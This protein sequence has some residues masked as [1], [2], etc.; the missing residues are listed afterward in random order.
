MIRTLGGGFLVIGGSESFAIEGDKTEASLGF[1]N[2][3]MVK[4]DEAGNTQWDR[5]VLDTGLGDGRRVVQLA[6]S[7]LVIAAHRG[8]PVG[9]YATDTVV[10]ESDLWLIKFA[11]HDLSTA[12]SEARINEGIGLYTSLPDGTVHWT[13][14]DGSDFVDALELFDADGRSVR[15]VRP[16]TS[17]GSWR[18]EGLAPGAYVVR[19]L[20]RSGRSVSCAVMLHR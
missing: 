3:W 12:S 14:T 4:L 5:T 16:R 6:D 17:S 11:L 7:S 15:S 1:F 20:L 10:G 2:G 9:G 8:G 13:V 18:P 19:A